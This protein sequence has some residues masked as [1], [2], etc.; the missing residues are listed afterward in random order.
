M[1]GAAWIILFC[2]TTGIVLAGEPVTPR[3]VIED[4]Q[5]RA[6]AKAV[7]AER[8]L[9][10]DPPNTPTGMSSGT[11]TAILLGV[12]VIGAA[13]YLINENQKQHGGEDVIFS[14]REARRSPPMQFHHP[15]LCQQW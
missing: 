7:I 11:W 4:S 13:I 5:I 6:A 2:F 15:L 9:T 8:G 14:A 1:K 10:E 3:V 12:I